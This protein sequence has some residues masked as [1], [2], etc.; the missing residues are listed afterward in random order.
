[1]RF[2]NDSFAAPDTQL[3]ILAHLKEGMWPIRIPQALF[4]R[5]NGYTKNRVEQLVKLKRQHN[6]D[7]RLPVAR[8]PA[9]RAPIPNI[10]R[11]SRR[12]LAN[13]P[14]FIFLRTLYHNYCRLLALAHRRTL[15]SATLD[16]VRPALP[17]AR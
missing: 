14:R 7:E 13:K 4:V 9:E 8:L 15:R 16:D 12:Q 1:M 3:D 17:H 6:S 5:M 2:Y 11:L 10:L